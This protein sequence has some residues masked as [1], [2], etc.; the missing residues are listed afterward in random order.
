MVGVAHEDFPRV[1]PELHDGWLF[2]VT[3][4]V[5]SVGVILTALSSIYNRYQIG[6]VAEKVD[7]IHKATNS[8]IDRA[9]ATKDDVIAAKDVIIEEAIAAKTAA[10]NS[11]HG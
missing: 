1:I 5:T 11:H 7:G 6:K 4:I 9:L 2:E 8:L 10:N 3:Q